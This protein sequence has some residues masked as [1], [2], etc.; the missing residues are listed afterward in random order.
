M[1]SYLLIVGVETLLAQDTAKN[2]L[3]ITG[4]AEVYYQRD[5]NNPE[6]NSRPEFIYSHNRNNEVSLNLGLVKAAYQTDRL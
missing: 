6:N 3:K 5:F 1:L 4:Y 2:E